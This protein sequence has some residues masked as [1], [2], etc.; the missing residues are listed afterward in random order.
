MSTLFFI[1]FHFFADFFKAVIFCGF[2]ALPMPYRYSISNCAS[3][4]SSM[5]IKM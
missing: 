1:N 3:P 2:P 4:L 5:S